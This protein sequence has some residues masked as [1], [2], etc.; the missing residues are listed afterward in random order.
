M[1]PVLAKNIII[2]YIHTITQS[3]ITAH[4]DHTLPFM[5]FLCGTTLV[6]IT[7]M[8]QSVPLTSAHMNIFHSII[9]SLHICPNSPPPNTTHMLHTR[10]FLTRYV[11]SVPP[12]HI[13]Q[14]I[15]HTTATQ[16]LPSRSSSTP[17]AA[18]YMK[19]HRKCNTPTAQILL[20]APSII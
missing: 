4:I 19:A 7:P 12:S 15:S 11:L 9:L 16:S 13:T 5:S 6:T 8:S 14:N 10:S 2:P 18:T 1:F 20:R 3:L 17:A